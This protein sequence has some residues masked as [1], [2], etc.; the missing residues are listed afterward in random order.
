MPRCLPFA[1]YFLWLAVGKSIGA[2]ERY[3]RRNKEPSR[4]DE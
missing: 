2:K 3:K 4:E 1:F